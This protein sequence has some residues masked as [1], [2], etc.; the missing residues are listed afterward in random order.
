MGDVEGVIDEPVLLLRRRPLPDLEQTTFRR[1]EHHR[2][3][4]MGGE[5]IAQSLPR[6]MNLLSSETGLNGDQQVV[7]QHAEKDVGL[8]SVLELMENRPLL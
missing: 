1:R 2:D 4:L 7:G 5:L 6:G 3:H 8:D